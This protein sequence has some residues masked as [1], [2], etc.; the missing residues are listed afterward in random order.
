[1]SITVACG[2]ET[3]TLEP[4]SWDTQVLGLNS[5]RVVDIAGSSATPDYAALTSKLRSLGFQYVIARR[6]QA[7]W[8]RFRAFEAAGFQLVDGILSYR[9]ELGSVPHATGNFRVATAADATAVGEMAARTFVYSRF[10]NDP[11]LSGK[12]AA[13]VHN[14]WAKNSVL[15]K[16]ADCVWLAEE[17]GR[18]MGFCTGKISGETGSIVLLAVD[19][20]F[21]G[22]GLGH[23]LS[24]KVCEWFKLQG[25]KVVTVQ[26][27]TSNVPAMSLYTS[28]GFQPFQSSYTL[29]W[30]P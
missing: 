13:H 16:A 7:E 9:R 2:N 17:N 20:N 4:L 27:Q 3:V 29:R 18:L 23:N 15:G 21:S 25:A 5:A 11:L 22:R 24:Y 6:P 12:M 19:K 28:A 1:M 10:H 30:A 26:T 8:S 14:E